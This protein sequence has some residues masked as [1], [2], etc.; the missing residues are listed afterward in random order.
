MNKVTVIGSGY[1]G[2]VVGACLAD[3]GNMVVCTDNNEHKIDELNQGNIPIYEAGINEMIKQNAGMG[4]LR[5][6]TDIIEAVKESDII[7]IAV[8][9]PP[10]E[11]GS[12]DIQH[13][14][15][16]SRE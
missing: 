6:T 2:I 14:L 13:V 15:E 12:A 1:V 7:F 11:D 5:F 9:T 16:V 10:M 3:M 8:G 4:R